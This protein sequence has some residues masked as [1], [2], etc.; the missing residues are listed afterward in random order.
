LYGSKILLKNS[1]KVWFFFSK[2]LRRLKSKISPKF[3]RFTISFL[4]LTYIF[5]ISPVQSSQKNYGISCSDLLEG[6]EIFS[7]NYENF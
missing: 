2:N 5:A 1:A 6:L 7:T 4:F 3:H